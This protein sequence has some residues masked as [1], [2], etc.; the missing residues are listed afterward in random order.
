MSSYM[1]YWVPSTADSELKLG[2]VLDHAAGEQL[3]DIKIGDTVW[4]ATV[5][6]GI[7]SLLGRIEVGTVTDQ[8]GAARIKKC[9]P[10]DLW[11]AS[12]HVL[13]RPGT[14]HETAELMAHGVASRIRFISSSG[15]DRLDME[16]GRINAQQLQRLRRLKK[17]SAELLAR[18]WADGYGER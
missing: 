12:F 5:R 17:E 14:A 11:E 6:D 7:F 18:F 9:D 16:G 10:V 1:H 4:V 3:G 2:D 15:A 13:A 8:V